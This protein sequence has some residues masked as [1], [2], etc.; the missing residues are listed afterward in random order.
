MYV[1]KGK[2]FCPFRSSKKIRFLIPVVGLMRSHSRG[3]TV[4][5]SLTAGFEAYV[6]FSAGKAGSLG[7]NIHVPF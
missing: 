3:S 4:A 1:Y 6:C 7:W 5:L 2:P